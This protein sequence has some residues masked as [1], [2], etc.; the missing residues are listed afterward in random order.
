MLSLLFVITL[1]LNSTTVEIPPDRATQEYLIEKVNKLRAQGCRC[2]RKKMP[3]VGPLE[4]DNKLYVSA[5]SHAK[6]LVGK[7]K[8]THYG[9]RGEDISERI[10]KTGY[11]WKVV[12]EN[13]G[14]GQQSFPQV[15]K[16][17]I[18][19][20]PHC[21]ML[22]NPKV[23]DMAVAKVNNIWVQHFGKKKVEE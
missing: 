6:Y 14:M 4:W 16:D 13:L 15:M 8:L 7:K 11:P 18:K 1:Y 3:P 21:K 2:G 5:R 12:G 19:S 22:M 17:W 20:T 10:A 23:E 9:K